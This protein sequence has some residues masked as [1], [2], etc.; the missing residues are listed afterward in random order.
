MSDQRSRKSMESKTVK[1][2]ETVYKGYRFRSRLEARWA[3]YFD[4]AGIEYEYEPE[5][6]ELSDGTR[7]LPD[8]YLPGFQIYA[9]VKPL[10]QTQDRL[11]IYDAQEK[12]CRMFRDE[13]A[14]I[15]LLRGTPWDDIWNWIFAWETD[16]GGGGD[17]DGNGKFVNAYPYIDGCNPIF[18][19]ADSRP[20]RIIWLKSD[21]SVSSDKVCSPG[22]VCD[23]Y[24]RYHCE[25]VMTPLTE[26]YDPSGIDKLTAAKRK[27]Q[28]ARFEY[29]EHGS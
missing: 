10:L 7:Y 26:F 28:Q 13:V 29:G 19:C 23:L 5:G 12:L 22:M 27:A 9:E 21:Y 24:P 18:M 1:P 3:V 6:F 15:L 4:E 17:Y 25:A 2:I 20:S 16:D 8:F 11:D 14:P